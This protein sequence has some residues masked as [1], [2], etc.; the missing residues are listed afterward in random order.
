MRQRIP[1]DVDRLRADIEAGRTI[2]SIADEYRCST[3]A[4]RRA[5]RREGIVRPEPRIASLHPELVDREWLQR[6]YVDQRRS[7]ADIARQ[8]GCD[9]STVGDYLKLAG[10]AARVRR[11]EPMP[12]E[13]RNRE[14]LAAAYADRSAEAIAPRTR[15]RGH[16]CSTSNA[17]A[18]ARGGPAS[19]AVTT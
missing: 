16:V 3:K 5:M 13:L 10:I 15:R 18:R 2:L 1:F 7:F 12:D 11:T 4:V 9:A 6:E 14:W 8:L 19:E 17:Q